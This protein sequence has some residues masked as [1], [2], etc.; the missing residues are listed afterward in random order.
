MIRIEFKLRSMVAPPTQGS[1]KSVPIYK[2]KGKS[3]KIIG[4]RIVD[5]HDED[6]KWWRSAVAREA[7]RNYD[8]EP[9]GDPVYARLDVL[10][11]MPRPKG[12][13][14]T[15]RNAGTVKRS[16]R[17]C[18][19]VVPDSL[20]M[21]RAIE[22][23]LKGVLYADD[24]QVTKHAIEKKYWTEEHYETRIAVEIFGADRPLF[25]ECAESEER[26]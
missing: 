18:P 12:H 8:G 11:L 24:C 10:Y 14:G 6:L 13:Y 21:T 20:K 7:R 23:A 25:Q 17:P 9:L 26:E 4:S 3:R 22:D 15:G 2:G 19:T 5:M 16:A 1:K